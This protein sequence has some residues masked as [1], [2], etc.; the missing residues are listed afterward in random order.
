MATGVI[1]AARSSLPLQLSASVG[2]T[3]PL[4]VPSN[5]LA[6]SQPQKWGAVVRNQVSKTGRS[7]TGA[8]Q[9]YFADD[10]FNRMYLSA[11]RV[12]FT[13]EGSAVTDAVT[14]WN[15]SYRTVRIVSLSNLSSFQI[16]VQ[17]VSVPMP[18]GPFQTATVRIT[19]ASTG[20][21]SVSASLVIGYDI[22]EPSTV[23]ITVER[24]KLFPNSPNWASSVTVGYEFKTE[25]ITSRDGTEQRR[26]LRAE[27][28]RKIEFSTLLH[29]QSLLSWKS[30]MAS[31]QANSFIIPEV[32]RSVAII[33]EI[34][35]GS[36]TARVGAM[37]VWAWDGARV[38]LSDGFTV[39]SLVIKSVDTTLG[40]IAFQSAVQT[41]FAIGSRITPTLFGRLEPTI[42]TNAFTN[43]TSQAQVAF[44]AYPGMQAP[45]DF[46]QPE[47]G[48]SNR[49]VLTIRPNWADGQQVDFIWDY[50]T[51]DYEI[52]RIRNYVPVKYGSTLT[53]PTFSGYTARIDKL[54]QFFLR[55]K[56]QAKSFY[57]PTGGRDIELLQPVFGGSVTMTAAS[58]NLADYIGSRVWR[59]IC[60]RLNDGTLLTNR[61]NSISPLGQN[62]TALSMD[63]PWPRSFS[64]DDVAV[65]SWMP[66]CRFA[67][68]GMTI[69]YRTDS[70]AV[71]ETAIKTLEEP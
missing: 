52:G 64:P 40:L 43:T 69:E 31:W 13:S 9:R 21:S 20:P 23:A 15:A 41:S 4:I 14:V 59:S 54:L 27:P 12:D 36:N 42:R 58:S 50:D 22:R 35:A 37:P 8:V 38:I 67:T 28:R 29:G 33:D 65:I 32:G 16:A 68:D 53:K 19:P 71:V 18:I 55:H 49:E 57:F 61:I 2:I 44:S 24:V 3:H 34:P 70:V 1:A 56:G 25:I 45:L 30:R 66:L 17:G 10:Y 6:A 62:R 46:G 26:A 63:F 48:F 47:L 11:S 39:K 7:R 60:V 51:I 5:T